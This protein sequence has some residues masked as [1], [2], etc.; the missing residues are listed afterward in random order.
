MPDVYVSFISSPAGKHIFDRVKCF[1]RRKKVK[2]AWEYALFSS[3]IKPC[4]LVLP[5]HKIEKNYYL[6]LFQDNGR[7]SELRVFCG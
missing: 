1:C 7:Y 3:I 2:R 4:I 6:C 5:F